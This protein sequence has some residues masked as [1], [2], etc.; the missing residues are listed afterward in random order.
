M[1]SFT[2]KEIIIILILFF[3][4]SVGLIVQVIVNVQLKPSNWDTA[5][6]SMQLSRQL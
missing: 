3:H 6:I 4:K 1:L 5:E 2:F